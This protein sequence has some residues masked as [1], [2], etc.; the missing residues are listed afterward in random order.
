MVPGALWLLLTACSPAAPGGPPPDDPRDDDDSAGSLA[1]GPFSAGPSLDFGFAGWAPEDLP[2]SAEDR[3]NGGGGALVDLDGDGDLDLVLTSPPG[4]N[5]VF[6][7]AGDAT[8]ERDPDP[9]LLQRPWTSSV[10]AAD[11]DGDGRPDLLLGADGALL[12]QRN[13]GDRLGDPEVLVQL[14]GDER[15]EGAAVA[16]L[17]GDGFVDVYVSVQGRH[18]NEA[19]FPPPF[20]PADR[21]LRG[22]PGGAFEDRSAL[23][24]EDA[25]IGQS[26]VATFFDADDD[27]DLDVFS[28]KD[29]G[30]RLVPDRLFLNPGSLDEAWSEGSAAAGLD[31]RHDGMGVAVG[32]VDGDGVLEI[33]LTDNGARLHVFGLDAGLAVAHADGL[34]LTPYAGEAQESSWGPA[35]ADLDGDGDLDAVIAFGAVVAGMDVRSQQ[36]GLWVWEDGRFVGR[37]DLFGVEPA[38]PDRATRCPL[39][40]DLN[41]DGAPDVVLVRQLGPPEI[42]LG[43]P[44]DARWLRVRLRG[45]IGNRDGLGARVRVEAAGLAPQERLSAA[46]AAGVHSSGPREL[47]FGLGRAEEATATV[48]WPD[49][50]TTVVD[51]ASGALWIDHPAR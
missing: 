46:G 25:R 9:G 11:V 34:G 28:V 45:G 43:E 27:G 7:N 5:A 44:N 6:W 4:D 39:V 16:D 2:E 19:K 29:H 36:S 23:L 22:G 37:P 40:G 17:D 13:L 33:V 30:E 47:V 32:D 10:T 26:Y 38:P 14:D 24:P 18:P 51:G 49:G 35:L 50:A 1:L 48:F 8:F 12:L 3:T 31:L 41:G 15:V 20:R 21:L 42:R